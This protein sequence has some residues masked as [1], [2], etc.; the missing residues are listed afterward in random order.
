MDDLIRTMSKNKNKANKENLEISVC[1]S[2]CNNFSN[3]DLD[4]DLDSSLWTENKV[5]RVALESFMLWCY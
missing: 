4:H 5:S 2:V 3:R 1:I